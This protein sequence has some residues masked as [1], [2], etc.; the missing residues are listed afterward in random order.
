MSDLDLAVY[1]KVLVLS[2]SGKYYLRLTKRRMGKV[3]IHSS[4]LYRRGLS[5]F[6]YKIATTVTVKYLA[7]ERYVVAPGGALTRTSQGV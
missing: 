7:Q 6:P 3:S 4:G 5:R 2:L 1:G